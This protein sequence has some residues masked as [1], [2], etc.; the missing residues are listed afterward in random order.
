MLDRRGGGRVTLGADKPYDVEAFVGALRQRAVTPPI[1]IQGVASKTGKVRK[2]AIDNR[3]LRHAGYA[4]SQCMRKRIEEIF[5]R[6]KKPGGLVKA[7]VRGRAKVEAVFAF[8]AAACSLIRIP[9]P[10]APQAPRSASRPPIRP[11]RAKRSRDPAPSPP[12]S[13]VRRSEPSPA[14]LFQQPANALGPPPSMKST[15]LQGHAS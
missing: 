6:I 8:A 14:P 10:L 11:P 4:I 15:K 7:K 1:A 9:K 3:T 12:F 13:T 2:T 5:G